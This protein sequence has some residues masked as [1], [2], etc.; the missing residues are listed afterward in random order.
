MLEKWLIL[1]VFAAAVASNVTGCHEAARSDPAVAKA[2]QLR[3][4]ELPRIETMTEGE[5]AE[6]GAKIRKQ[7]GG[8]TKEQRKAFFEQSAPMFAKVLVGEVD[9]ILALPA[10]EQRKE[11]DRKIDECRARNEAAPKT[12]PPVDPKRAEEM[13]N[14]VLSTMS[15]DDRQ[16]VDAYRAKLVERLKERGLPPD[17]DIF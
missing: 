8:M 17:T 10:D 14:R 2:E 6:S 9:R 4:A 7:T 12:S 16:K 5:R 13:R 3:D 1:A 15:A 11:L